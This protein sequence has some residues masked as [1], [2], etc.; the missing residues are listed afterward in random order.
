MYAGLLAGDM[1]VVL[2]VCGVLKLYSETTGHHVGTTTLERSDSYG[3]SDEDTGP[4]P[5]SD[6]EDSLLKWV[7][8]VVHRDI[9]SYSQYV[10]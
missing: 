5:L 9:D 2:A 6:E 1:K 3:G 4:P 10:S 7:G 8:S